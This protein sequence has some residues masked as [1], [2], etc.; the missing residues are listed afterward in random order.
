M[1]MYRFET[2][3]WGLTESERQ[4]CERAVERFREFIQ[5]KPFEVPVSVNEV[6]ESLQDAYRLTGKWDDLLKHHDDISH[7]RR[8]HRLI[9][10]MPTD[11]FIKKPKL[12][13]FCKPNNPTETENAITSLAG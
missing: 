12:I 3:Y 13:C 5:E 6:E 7:L 9:E 2:L 10:Q 8:S 11:G 1:K 4:H